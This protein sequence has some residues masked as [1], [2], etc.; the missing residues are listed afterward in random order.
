VWKQLWPV[1][2][3]RQ[4]EFFCFGMDILLKLDLEV[5][6]HFNAFFDLEPHY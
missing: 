2:T 5:T 3:R 1:I 4:M 6:H